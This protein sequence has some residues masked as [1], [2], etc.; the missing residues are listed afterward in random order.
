[1]VSE[2]TMTGFKEFASISAALFNQGWGKISKID[3]V[4]AMILIGHW[5]SRTYVK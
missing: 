4:K 3:F 2:R 1:L 5:Q